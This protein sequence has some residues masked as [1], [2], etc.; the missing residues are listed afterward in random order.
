MAINECIKLNNVCLF[1]ADSLPLQLL[2]FV[3][4]DPL[5]INVS[6]AVITFTITKTDTTVAALSYTLAAD[7]EVTV[8]GAGNN[9]VGYFVGAVD[10][11][12]L[13]VGTYTIR[14]KTQLGA[15][16]TRTAIQ[17]LDLTTATV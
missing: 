6:S 5:P 13:T 14:V 1:L 17:R 12:T 11:A 7:A 10:M 3:D 16:W 4:Q 8:T 9:V 2:I 15:T